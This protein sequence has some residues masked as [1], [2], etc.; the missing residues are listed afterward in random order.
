MPPP[1]TT[2]S[3]QESPRDAALRAQREALRNSPHARELRAFFA[4]PA[5]ADAAKW[6]RDRFIIGQPAITGAESS[7]ALTFTLGR[8]HGA[9]ELASLL[10]GYGG[11]LNDAT[12]SDDGTGTP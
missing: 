6:L 9:K 7:A 12:M 11:R 10:L 3:P 8:F 4:T 1:E 2:T 5:G